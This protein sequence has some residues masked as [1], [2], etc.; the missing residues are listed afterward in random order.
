MPIATKHIENKIPPR[1]WFEVCYL[2][3]KAMVADQHLGRDEGS[4]GWDGVREDEK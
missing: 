3:G 4:V 2:E 1:E